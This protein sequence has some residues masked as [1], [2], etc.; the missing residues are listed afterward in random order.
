M[1]SLLGIRKEETFPKKDKAKLYGKSVS[2]HGQYN[3]L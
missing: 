3:E 2:F 1:R